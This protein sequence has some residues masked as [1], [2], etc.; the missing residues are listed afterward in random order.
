MVKHHKGYSPATND[1]EFFLLD[2]SPKSTR[3]A[4]RGFT[5]VINEFGGNCLTC[6]SGAEPRWDMICE[7]DHGCDPNPITPVMARA[8]QNTD[9]R[10]AKVSLP[11]VQKAA[12][13][14]LAALLEISRPT[15]TSA[16]R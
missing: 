14:E 15:R 16:R 6:H 1:W 7:Q 5:N 2:V 12:L 13:R 11:P 8:I 10:C 9:P 4:G 3:I